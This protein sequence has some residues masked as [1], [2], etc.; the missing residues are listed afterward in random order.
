MIA[1]ANRAVQAAIDVV[2]PQAG[3]FDAYIFGHPVGGLFAVSWPFFNGAKE[4]KGILAADPIPGT[5]SLPAWLQSSAA[6]A[7]VRLADRP[8]LND[9]VLVSDTG[10]GLANIPLAVLIGDSDLYVKVSDWQKLWPDLATDQKRIYVSQAD[11]YY[12]IYRCDGQKA[13]I[14]DYNQSVTNALFYGADNL[15]ALIGGPGLQ[16]DLRWRYV[17]AAMDAMLQ[18]VRTDQL[19]FDMGCWSND[20]QV[21]PV[22]AWP[23]AGG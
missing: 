15:Q 4:I 3:D 10:K 17:W 18:G 14:A 8:F 6:D 2:F 19:S 22:N 23:T 11:S 12:G 7:S 16:N 9:P 5:A 1:N 21:K 13:L 20:K